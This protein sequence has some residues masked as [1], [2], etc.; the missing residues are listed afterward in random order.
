[1]TESHAEDAAAEAL[2]ERLR[3]AD[4]AA[5]LPPA[6][7]ERVARLLEDAMSHDLL[8]ETGESR[9]TGTRGRGPLTW[10]VAAAAA[11]VIVGTGVAIALNGNDDTA[12]EVPS[13]GDAPTVTALV[14]PSP[15]E[16][17]CMQPSADLLSTKP[18]AFA[19][20]VEAIE[21]GMVTLTPTRWYAGEET[22]L[23]TVDAPD[24]RL[25]TLLTSVRFA[26]GGQYLVAANE[27][28]SVMVCGFSAP[29]SAGL[30]NLYAEAFPD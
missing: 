6:A 19:G 23:V 25:N 2:R 20:T 17:R 28:G 11:V 1:V 18:V 21:D 7:P 26:E 3:S 10:A 4:P 12:E 24:E 22:D 14:A 15:D 5:S 29:W 16:R 30:E 27:D 9:A 13:A 8:P